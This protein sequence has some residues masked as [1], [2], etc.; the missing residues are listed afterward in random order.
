MKGDQ[1]TKMVEG[2]A[3]LVSRRGLGAA[4]MR[5]L[6]RHAGTPLGSTYHYFP[7]GK[8]QLVQEAVVLTGE[9]VHTALAEALRDGPVEG[10]RAFL[11]IWRRILVASDFEAGCPVLSVSVSE[12]RHGEAGEAVTAARDV[13]R[14][15]RQ[16]LSDGLVEGGC[17]R[18]QADSLALLVVAAVEGTVGMCRAEGS[19]GPLDELEKTVVDLIAG[20]VDHNTR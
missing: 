5:D 12:S 16:V 11:E 13:F 14:D 18:A 2:A 17:A 3:D 6:A 4:S 1:R 10:I 15:W 19:T 20:A 8:R 7:G 9:R